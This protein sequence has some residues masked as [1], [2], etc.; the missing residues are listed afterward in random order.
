MELNCLKTNINTI[1][2]AEMEIPQ[3]VYAIGDIHGKWQTIRNLYELNKDVFSSIRPNVLILLGDAGLNY[4]LNERDEK[5]KAQLGKYPFTYFVIRG[6]H[7]E[8]PSIC[9][10][11]N[12]ELWHTETFWGNTVYVENQFPYIKYALDE[13]ALY[14][15][16]Y[17]IDYC[18]GTKENEYN[19]EGM[20]FLSTYK[21]LVIPVSLGDTLAKD[22]AGTPLSAKGVESL[23]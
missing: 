11:K 16:P 17:V 4:F 13:V 7:E 20:P 6:N 9:A 2:Q 14:E 3:N 5:T 10:A 8:R 18:D 1:R 19:D 23:E 12:P 21:T 15:I 22:T